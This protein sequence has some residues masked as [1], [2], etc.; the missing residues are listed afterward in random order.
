MGL[1]SVVALPAE[2]VEIKTVILS[3]LG[4]KVSDVN[5]LYQTSS[6]KTLSKN[7]RGKILASFFCFWSEAKRR[8]QKLDSGATDSILPDDGKTTSL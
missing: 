7:G 2:T 1:F 3:F 6:L 8:Q 5:M 4:A